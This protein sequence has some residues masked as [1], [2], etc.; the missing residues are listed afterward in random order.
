[1]MAAQAGN[2]ET[3]GQLLQYKAKVNETNVADSSALTYAARAGFVEIGRLLLDAGAKVDNVDELGQTPLMAAAKSGRAEFVELLLQKGAKANLKDGKGNTALMLAASFGDYPEVVRA[4]VRGGADAKAKDSRGRTAAA[5]ASMR[6][7]GEEAKILGTPVAPVAK[8]PAKAVTMSVKLLE[9]SMAAFSR[10]VKC[11]SCH[12]EGLGRMLTA[13]ARSRGI[14]VDPELNQAQ[15]GRI[16]GGLNFMR[17]LH[18][19]ALKDP[20]T[21]P[22]DMTGRPMS[23]WVVVSAEGVMDEADLKHW[24]NLGVEYARTLPA[25]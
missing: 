3:V 21:R 22:F 10:G 15:L 14:A 11:I 7:F 5:L 20:H 16:R 23:G 17:P 9:S 24:I 19:Q 12:Q 8:D 6:G 13:S 1:M 4:L 25:K 18:E 2:P